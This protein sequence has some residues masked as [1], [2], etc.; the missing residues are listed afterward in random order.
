[1]KSLIEVG[2]E[3]TGMLKIVKRKSSLAGR[4]VP[5]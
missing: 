5:G 2:K 1:M 3:V 4:G